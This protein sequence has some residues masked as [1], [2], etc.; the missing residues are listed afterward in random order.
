MRSRPQRTETRRDVR[1]HERT[2]QPRPIC[3]AS[4]IAISYRREHCD[5]TSNVAGATA[6]PLGDA[7][8]DDHTR[9]AEKD[10]AAEGP[11]V[12]LAAVQWRLAQL[13]ARLTAR[14][15][16]RA[17]RKQLEASMLAENVRAHQP[18]RTAAPFA[19]ASRRESNR[20]V[21]Q[22]SAA[23]QS[24]TFSS[25]AGVAHPPLTTARSDLSLALDNV[26][27][28]QSHKDDTQT[29]SMETTSV[30]L[31]FPDTLSVEGSARSAFHRLLQT[32]TN[33]ALDSHMY[34]LVTVHS[35]DGND[36][37]IG[38]EDTPS[39]SHL[40]DRHSS[41]S[42]HSDSAHPH[43]HNPSQHSSTTLITNVQ[44]DHSR[45]AVRSRRSSFSLSVRG[46][47]R[48]RSYRKRSRTRNTIR[49]PEVDLTDIQATTPYDPD[50]SIIHVHS[51]VY[52]PGMDTN[53]SLTNSSRLT[54]TS[55][56][57]DIHHLMHSTLKTCDFCIC[58]HDW[59]A[60]YIAY[61]GHDDSTMSCHYLCQAFAIGIAFG[62]S[63]AFGLVGAARLR[64]AFPY[65]SRLLASRI[66]LLTWGPASSRDA[67]V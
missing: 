40:G 47:G 15:Q 6:Y 50:D 22:S 49:P 27:S 7:A 58:Q 16:A 21:S 19:P 17:E 20:M 13:E 43:C 24:T 57:R 59:F 62:I 33:D 39:V 44:D 42:I 8:M 60:D 61:A 5:L 2:Y 64:H 41:T 3:Q 63:F 53:N 25:D 52:I 35:H 9:P 29:F 54:L 4:S 14:E 48:R 38:S 36:D 18:K 65:V 67:W 34:D 26:Y 11:E 32:R 1:Y 66:W 10:A 12:R 46:K 28:G 31:S 55:F 37:G 30:A 45:S 23:S 56:S 51:S